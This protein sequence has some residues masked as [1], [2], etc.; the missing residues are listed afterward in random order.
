[1]TGL[2]YASPQGRAGIDG[3]LFVPEG[4]FQDPERCQKV[5]IPP[6]TAHRTK[7]QLALEMLESALD[8][9]VPARWVVGDEV[10]GSDG[11]LRRALETRG[12]A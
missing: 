6:G 11:K 5:G 12:Q 9:G 3:A 4:W 1:M 7:P 2:G 10:Y 8:A